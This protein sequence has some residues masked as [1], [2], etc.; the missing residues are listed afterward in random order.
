MTL[1]WGL[2]AEWRRHGVS[3]DVCEVPCRDVNFRSK[4]WAI[5]V[6]TGC[7]W[8]WMWCGVKLVSLDHVDRREEEGLTKFIEKQF[9]GKLEELAEYWVILM[10]KH[11]VRF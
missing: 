2:S 10:D 7:V 9:H 6:Q 1:R 3:F 5:R 11:K 4:L 8:E